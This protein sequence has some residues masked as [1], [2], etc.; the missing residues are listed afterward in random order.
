MEDI[1]DF[2]QLQHSLEDLP[3]IAPQD[4]A[5]DAEMAAC[6]VSLVGI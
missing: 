5:D 3:D 1:T 2:V 6:L 4:P